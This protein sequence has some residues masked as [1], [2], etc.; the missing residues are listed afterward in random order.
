[1][2]PAPLDYDTDADNFLKAVFTVP[3]WEADVTN[4]SVPGGP[5]VRPEH[6]VILFRLGKDRR[7]YPDIINVVGPKI[8]GPGKRTKRHYEV[9]FT[10]VAEGD[11]GAPDYA[12][13]EAEALAAKLNA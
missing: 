9:P 1:M 2:K 6:V 4:P 10:N 11:S 13:A 3:P 5:T 7:W 8:T 12:V